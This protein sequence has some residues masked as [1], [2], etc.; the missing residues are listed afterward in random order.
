MLIAAIVTYGIL[1]ANILVFHHP[2]FYRQRALDTAN[3]FETM[4]LTISAASSAA[5]DDAA[6]I[7]RFLCRSM[8]SLVT[9]VS[10]TPRH[11]PR[12]ADSPTRL[13]SFAIAQPQRERR[14]IG[15]ESYLP[16]YSICHAAY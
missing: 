10:P 1:D 15:T 16:K 3:R 11:S 6:H 12:E 14:A 4:L 8:L 9:F 2:A 7:C 5:D 13:T